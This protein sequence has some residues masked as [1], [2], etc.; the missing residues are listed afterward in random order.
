[1][2]CLTP[3][4]LSRGGEIDV[5]SGQASLD[6][7]ENWVTRWQGTWRLE[8]ADTKIVLPSGESEA[9]LRARR[10]RLC[11][12]RDSLGKMV[13]GPKWITETGE[14][15]IWSDALENQNSSDDYEI[16][17]ANHEASSDDSD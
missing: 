8:L 7:V 12:V 9:S 13:R 15:Y 11:E 17:S 6:E 10:D 5:S 2:A 4:Q 1:M 14:T 3:T 16:S